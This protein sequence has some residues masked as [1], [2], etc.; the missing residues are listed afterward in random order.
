VI[1]EHT[2][3]VR[4]FAGVYCRGQLEGRRTG[5]EPLKLDI[6]HIVHHYLSDIWRCVAISIWNM[7]YY[8]SS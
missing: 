4:I 6:I 7:Y 1:S 3:F 5:V 2:R 8:E